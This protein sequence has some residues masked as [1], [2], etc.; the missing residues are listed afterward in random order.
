MTLRDCHVLAYAPSHTTNK[1]ALP[2]QTVSWEEVEIGTFI[3]NSVLGG[4]DDV[5]S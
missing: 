1:T 2:A 3:V 5:R 4:G